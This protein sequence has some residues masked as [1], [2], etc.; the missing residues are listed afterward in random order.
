MDDSDVDEP[1]D[2]PAVQVNSAL[3]DRLR[4]RREPDFQADLAPSD[5]SKA[6]VLFKP[7]LPPPP[8]NTSKVEEESQVTEIESS[9]S[10]VDDQSMQ[11]DELTDIIVDVVPI[12]DDDAMEVEEI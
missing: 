8:E 11:D 5:S 4:S 6:L 9:S 10:S 1:T 2:E 3:L 12:D 7:V